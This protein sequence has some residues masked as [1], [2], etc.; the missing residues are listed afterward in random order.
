MSSSS[1][2]PEKYSIDEMMD[3]LKSAPAGAP[4]EGELVIRSDGT[5]AIKV[6]RRKRRTNQPVKKEQLV[7]GRMRVLQVSA[8]L[9][10][11]FLTAL[12]IGGAIIYANSSP[13]REALVRRIEQ[14][15]GAKVDLQLFRMNP[16]TANASSLAMQ[17]P[18]GNVLNSLTLAGL[19]AEV[20]P[21]SFLGNAMKGEEVSATEG[22]LTLRFPEVGEKTRNA[23]SEDGPLPIRFNRYRVPSLSL[24]LGEP[25][26]P[27]IKITKSEASLNPETVNGSSQLSFYRGDITIA[28]WPKLRLDRALV[29]F[30]GSE[31]DIVGLRVLHETDS[32]GIFELSGTVYPYQPDHLSSLEVLLQSFEIGGITGPAMGR[33]FSGRIDSTPATKSNFLSFLP[34]ADS[35]TTLEIAFQVS[36]SSQIELR[37]FPFLLALS[38][39]LDDPWFQSPVFSTDASGS[40]HRE[41][42]TITLRDLNL[43]S[44]GRIAIRGQI[45]MS[46][47]QQLS[48]TLDVGVAEAMI[49]SAKTSSDSVRLKS[50]FGPSREGFRWAT[51]KISGPVVT[52][53]DNFKDIFLATAATPADTTAPAESDGSSF[54]ELTR[55]K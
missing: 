7:N 27:V 25:T 20:F 47:D 53:T 21:S 12:F 9:V 49:A 41:K 8:A 32:R 16:K 11:V 36:P 44:K 4:E 40:I 48:G 42:G 54:E 55:P 34:T 17:W 26:A 23:P 15:S 51:L 45:S 13:F 46:A 30:R 24:T 29:E 33:L 38:Q 1:S 31:A 2:E 35:T 22:T 19:N 52:P 10:L 50:M 18:S 3:R 5:Q 37:G 28:G 39:I 43:E 14:A 6:R